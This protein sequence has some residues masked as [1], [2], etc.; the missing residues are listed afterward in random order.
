MCLTLFL[1]FFQLLFC[2]GSWLTNEAVD[3][4]VNE[5]EKLEHYRLAKTVSKLSK[6]DRSSAPFITGNGFMHIANVIAAP[7]SVI[8]IQQNDCIFISRDFYSEFVETYMQLINTSYTLIVHNGDESTPDGQ[9]DTVGYRYDK[10]VTSQIL[11][12]EHNKKKLLS[13]Y[14]SNL[15]WSNYTLNPRPSYFHCIPIGLENREHK[16][17]QNL[18]QYI[19]AMKNSMIPNHSANKGLLLVPLTPNSLDRA[20]VLT[21]LEKTVKKNGETWYNHTILPHPD[22]LKAITEHKFVLAPFG[23][24][25]DTHRMY[26]IWLMGGIPVARKSTISSCFNDEDTSIGGN[27]SPGGSLPVVFLDSW[28][29]L[30]KKRLVEEWKK[31]VKVSKEEWNWRRLTLGHWMERLN[32]PTHSHRHPVIHHSHTGSSRLSTTTWNDKNKET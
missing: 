8:N 4:F 5:F 19:N 21:W 14:A 31:I 30:T 24:G 9:N 25:L 12:E 28:D 2:R 18:N 23:N 15:W 17:G 13:L 10:I 29:Q 27:G 11:L 3:Y 1:L 26:E 6:D 20:K 16:Y 22:W 32:C 7:N